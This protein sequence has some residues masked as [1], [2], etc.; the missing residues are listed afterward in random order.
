MRWIAGY[1]LFVAIAV[2]LLVAKEQPF[3]V[4]SW[5]NSSQP[6]LRFTFF[7]FKEIGSMGKERTYITDVTADNL[8][9]KMGGGSFT[10]YVFDKNNARIGQG[11]INLT[12]VAAGQT[13]KFQITLSASGTPSSVS[14]AT[15]APQIVSITVNSVPHGAVFKVDGKEGGTT[16]KMI[17]LAIGQHMLEFSKAGFS[18]G[19]FPL[20]ITPRDVSGGSVSYELGSA[21]HDTIEMR[22]GSVLEGDLISITGM[23][24]EVRIAGN[25]Q[26]FDRNQ[27]KRILLTPREPASN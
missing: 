1:F 12:N 15:S 7:K 20:E 14:V 19:R 16:P 21:V 9:E 26:T 8:S 27:L 24:V 17:D 2:S 13:V 11:Y 6:T 18:P 4:V 25:V 3:Q 5:P 22:D 23:H 10:L